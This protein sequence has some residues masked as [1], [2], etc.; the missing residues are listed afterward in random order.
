MINVEAIDYTIDLI[1]SVGRVDMKFSQ[2]PGSPQSSLAKNETEMHSCKNY[3]CIAGYVAI[4]QHFHDF[5]GHMSEAHFPVID[6][7][8]TEESL[9]LYFGVAIKFIIPLIFGYG[10][11]YLPVINWRFWRAPEAIKALEITRVLDYGNASQREYTQLLS[12]V[13]L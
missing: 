11:S 4:S 8:T 2:Q 9:S 7:F 6:E 13:M 1:R 10:E 3:A 12:E 5:G